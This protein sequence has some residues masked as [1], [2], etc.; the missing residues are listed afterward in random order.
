MSK[1]LV[2]SFFWVAL[3]EVIY[4][5]SAYVIHSGMGRILGPAEYGRFGIVVTLTTMIVVLIGQGVPTAMAKYLGE[6]YDTNLGLIP[7]I[8]RQTAKI[9]FALIG[10]VTVIF[11]LLSPVISNI[12]GDPSLTN[13]FRLS[14]LVIPAFALASFYFYYY[15][16]LHEFSTQAWLKTIRSVAR[17]GFILGLA[18][19]LK[20]KGLALEGAIVGYVFAP[21]FVFLAATLFDPYRKLKPEGS[22][23]WRKLL[24]YAWPM[25]LFLIAYE[26]LITIDLYLVKGILRDDALTGLYNGAIT[27]GRIP[28][29]LFYALTIIILPA[30]SKS[31][32][33]ENHSE[34]K[35]L[36]SQSLRLMTM[37]LLPIAILMSV[38]SEPILEIFYGQKF[39]GAAGPMS[40]LMSGVTF[41][42]IFYVMAFALNGAG[43]VKA[44]MMI[45]FAGLAT[46][47]A[48]SYFF[49]H[50]YGITGAAV[51]TS[52]TSFVSMALVLAYSYRFFGYLF[53]FSSFLKILLA[54]AIMY[55]ASIFF[56]EGKYVFILWSAILFAVYIFILYIFREFGASDLEILKQLIAKK[57]LKTASDVEEEVL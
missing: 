44:P 9:Q 37:F 42:T 5:L 27:V 30:V 49:I 22:F 28:Y 34:T 25:T 14:S 39:L 1:F 15:T 7:T 10:S 18:Y 23:D 12:L 6:I 38:Y 53:K 16:G 2:K 46:N 8:K 56:P 47:I 13:L 36:I 31:T 32:S 41:L 45:A 35:K 21:F 55:F 54:S 4:N 24:H 57:K 50:Q 52:I 48:L 19:Y 3:S 17:L 33:S 29:F 43:K 26:F 11:F 40:I 20:S 51:A